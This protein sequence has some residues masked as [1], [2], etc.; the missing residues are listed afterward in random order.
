MSSS[1]ILPSLKKLTFCFL[2]R[3]QACL[4]FFPFFIHLFYQLAN[5][6]HNL[7]WAVFLQKI[8][9]VKRETTN[10]SISM[11]AL[12]PG[13]CWKSIG[14]CKLET[15]L[16]VVKENG[17][18]STSDL[19]SDRLVSPRLDLRLGDYVGQSW[20]LR[21]HPLF[22]RSAS[23]SLCI[24]TSITWSFLFLVLF[25]SF[26]PSPGLSIICLLLCHW[27]IDSNA[28]SWM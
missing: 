4:Q 2:F 18:V 19:T 12:V 8:T 6:L 26:L 1:Y 22:P 15:R 25:R 20:G 23:S 27:G 3:I 17:S 24:P 7:I 9:N 11:A 16:P 10:E 14:E 13:S 28:R 21:L 5:C